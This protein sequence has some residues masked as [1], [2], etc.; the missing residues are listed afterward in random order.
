MKPLS[1][2]ATPWEILDPLAMQSAPF[3]DQSDDGIL[4]NDKHTI[5]TN[6]R[7]FRLSN[8][9]STKAVANTKRV[10][11]TSWRDICTLFADDY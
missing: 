7:C 11:T 3:L 9:Q 8:D 10:N 5:K 1:K 6:E 4:T 2:L